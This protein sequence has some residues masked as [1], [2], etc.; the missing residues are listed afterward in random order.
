MWTILSRPSSD[1]SISNTFAKSLTSP[2]EEPFHHLQEMLCVPPSNSKHLF[3]AHIK[4]IIQVL[5]GTCRG[6]IPVNCTPW[7]FHVRYQILQT[8]Q[9]YFFLVLSEFAVAL[10][11]ENSVF[12]T[13]V[14]WERYDLQSSWILTSKAHLL[15]VKIIY[16][17]HWV[18]SPLWNRT[19][20]KSRVW[21]WQQ[22]CDTCVLFS[23]E[24]S[25]HLTLQSA[26][27]KI[28]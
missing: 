18:G 6:R 11:Q 20:E 17:T 7:H 13:F 15:K 26:E 21:L 19:Q 4:R 27:I 16:E 9:D 3:V 2:A 14:N 23:A 12:S 24:L 28:V 25:I 22:R 1:L 8:V 10:V 5:W